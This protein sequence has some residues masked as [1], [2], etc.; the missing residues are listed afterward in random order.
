VL[1][2]VLLQYLINSVGS[3]M[4][5]S[6]VWVSERSMLSILPYWLWPKT[7]RSKQ[8]LPLTPS[9]PLVPRK[10]TS[11]QVITHQLYC[12]VT[13]SYHVMNEKIYFFLL[14]ITNPMR[15]ITYVDTKAKSHHLKHLSI[16]GFCGICLSEIIDI[17]LCWYI[18]DQALWTIDIFLSQLCELLL[19]LIRQIRI[20][21]KFRCKYMC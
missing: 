21:E 10:K 15:L 9:K 13:I 12:T 3:L 4:C 18:F 14:A 8:N 20:K 16:K 2:S 19:F 17:Y 5:S 6:Q 1:C 11:S 7:T